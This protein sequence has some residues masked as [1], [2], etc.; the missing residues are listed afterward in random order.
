MR[1]EISTE[2]VDRANREERSLPDHRGAS[3]GA[4]TSLTFT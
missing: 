4:H 3:L 2:G 1:E